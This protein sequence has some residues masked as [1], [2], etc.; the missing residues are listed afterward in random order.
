[1]IENLIFAVI[2][3]FLMFISSLI[4]VFF[5]RI[6]EDEARYYHEK[7]KKVPLEWLR[8]NDECDYYYLEVLSLFG[9]LIP[10][11][12]ASVICYFALEYEILDFTNLKDLL[13]SILFFPLYFLS[14]MIYNFCKKRGKLKYKKFNFENKTDNKNDNDS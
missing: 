11:I 3:V 2:L 7:G 10:Y 5:F 14:K 9:V 6:D 13:L 4:F 8:K 1:M 12:I